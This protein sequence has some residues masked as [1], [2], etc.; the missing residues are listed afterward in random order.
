MKCINY[1]QGNVLLQ[2]IWY[3]LLSNYASPHIKIASQTLK[4]EY[5]YDY[6]NVYIKAQMHTL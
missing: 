4:Q 2:D 1:I 3:V 6:E 5:I